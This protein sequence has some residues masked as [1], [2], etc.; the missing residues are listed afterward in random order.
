MMSVVRFTFDEHTA[1]YLSRALGFVAWG[2]ATGSV[3]FGAL[4]SAKTHLPKPAWTLVVHRHLSLLTLLAVT[5]HV[6]VLLFD[7]WMSPSVVELL[8]PMSD[9]WKPA[10][11]AAGQVAL[12]LFLVAQLSGL[13]RAK[14][15]RRTF[16][17]LHLAAIPAWVLATVHYLFG[18]SDTD[19]LASQ[20]FASVGVVAV[21]A[22]FAWRGGAAAGRT[23]RTRRPAATQPAAQP[24]A[25]PADSTTPSVSASRP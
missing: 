10:V 21:V 14:L 15:S 24:A 1:W 18:G 12:Y 17:L 22:A 4:F 13:F 20:V 11:R 25:Q 8:V 5:G 16:H 3:V 2:C 7:K 9:G 6:A 23:P 19:A